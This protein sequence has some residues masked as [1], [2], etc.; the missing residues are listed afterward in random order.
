MNA[1][2]N[3]TILYVL[4]T[5]ISAIF[6]LYNSTGGRSINHGQGLEIVKKGTS[7]RKILKLQLELV[8]LR[9]IASFT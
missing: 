4:W 3:G 8:N 2:K 6:F 9:K 7:T 1:Y 5:T